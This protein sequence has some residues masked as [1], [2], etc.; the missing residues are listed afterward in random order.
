[1]VDELLGFSDFEVD[2]LIRLMGIVLD[3]PDSLRRPHDSL[4]ESGSMV[5]LCAELLRTR[6]S[7]VVLDAVEAIGSRVLALCKLFVVADIGRRGTAS[8]VELAPV[9]LK[10]PW[11]LEAL[12]FQDML[13]FLLNELMDDGVGGSS[14]VGAGPGDFGTCLLV[15]MDLVVLDFL[16]VRL[17]VRLPCT[18]LY[19]PLTF[20]RW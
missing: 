13:N 14:G 16:G 19:S 9:S 18:V 4:L 20:D 1:M 15:S 17:S 5:K 8:L 11:F 6:C 12:R 10:S 3:S 2:D 7:V